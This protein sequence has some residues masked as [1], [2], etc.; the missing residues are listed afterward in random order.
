M[1]QSAPPS[2]PDEP[3]TIATGSIGLDDILGGGLDADRS[4]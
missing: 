2:G 3:A 4:I 1:T